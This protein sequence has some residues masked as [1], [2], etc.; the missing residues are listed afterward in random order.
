MREIEFRGKAII[1]YPEHNIVKGQ[2]VYGGYYENKITT[3]YFIVISF[4]QYIHSDIRVTPETVGLYAG[5][6][7]NNGTNIY[8]GDIFKYYKK[9]LLV[10]LDVLKGL[11]LEVLNKPFRESFLYDAPSI[12]YHTEKIEQIGNI[13][14]NPELLRQSYWADV[15]CKTCIILHDKETGNCILCKSANTHEERFNYYKEAEL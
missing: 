13:H 7:Y 4:E 11:T 1:D 2:W 8:E 14:D 5:V 15:L 12:I 3:R 6:K 10:K 9:I